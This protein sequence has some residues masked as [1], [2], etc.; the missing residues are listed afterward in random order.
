MKH[1]ASPSHHENKTGG[2]EKVFKGIAYVYKCQHLR[3]LIHPWGLCFPRL[4][5]APVGAPTATPCPWWDGKESG[6]REEGAPCDWEQSHME[7]YELVHRSSLKATD[8][9][10]LAP[11]FL[12]PANQDRGADMGLRRFREGFLHL[13]TTGKPQIRLTLTK[14]AWHSTVNHREEVSSRDRF[15]C[16]AAA[17]YFFPGWRHTLGHYLYLLFHQ[18]PHSYFS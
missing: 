12:L 4:I 5:V 2:E 9:A 6:E 16:S 11:H 15:P 3:L 18:P 8:T 1:I 14:G 13:Q 10:T 17:F 7:L